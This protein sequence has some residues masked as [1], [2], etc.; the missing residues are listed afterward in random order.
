MHKKT[1]ALSLTDCVNMNFGILGVQFAWSL[2][3]TTISGI[4]A[5]LGATPSSLGFL[6]LAFP[7]TGI[8]MQI[9]IGYLSDKTTSSW[10]KRLPYIFWFAC[11]T[12][13]SMLFI[14]LSHSL[15][16]TAFL[17]WI[18]TAAVNAAFIPFKP[19]I[20]DIADQQTHTKVYAIQAILIGFGASIASLTPWLILHLSH[21]VSQSH[22]NHVPFEITWSYVIGASTIVLACVWTTLKVKKLLPTHT[23]TITTDTSTQR[24][25][26]Q[27]I[28]T[29]IPTTMWQIAAVQFFTWTGVFLFFIYLTP[30]I[31]HNIYHLPLHINMIS[32][33]HLIKIIEKSTLLTGAAS[34]TYTIASIV[35]ASLIPWMSQA[36]SRKYVYFL[37]LLIGGISFIAI[38]HIH[39]PHI[40][41]LTMLGFGF[42]WAS[43]SSIPYAILARVLPEN[44]LGAYMGIL[45]I[46]ICLPQI[47]VGL[48]T[49]FILTHLLGQNT[50]WLIVIAGA[51][52]I[53]AAI[54][55]LI[56]KDQE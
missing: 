44:T 53:I 45:N 41:L 19:L 23:T 32:H 29:N 25:S 48:V 24:E 50:A 9:L 40:L 3:I 18:F 30:I 56:I 42:A 7:I 28:I 55:V 4:Y 49:G 12:A 38:Y 33:A 14:P 52:L 1:R 10:G 16:I 54:L 11:L 26:W 5:F 15:I 31:E 21:K 35:F 6:W 8:I 2:V 46:A 47:I 17:L 20:A 13:A 36:I 34:A 51:S 39:K 37:S 22:S 43:I 27:N